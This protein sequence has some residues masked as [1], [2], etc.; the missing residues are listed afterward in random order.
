MASSLKSMPSVREKERGSA[1]IQTTLYE[2]IEAVNEEVDELDRKKEGLVVGIV[3]HLLE[4]GNVRARM[5]F[6]KKFFNQKEEMHI[7]NH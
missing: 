7:V 2:L 1:S 4:T 6:N 5:D 3:A